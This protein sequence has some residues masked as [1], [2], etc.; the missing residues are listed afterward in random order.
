VRGVVAT[1]RGNLDLAATSLAEALDIA[2]LH[3]SKMRLMQVFEALGGLVVDSRPDLCV[4]L[5][6]AAEQLRGSLGAIPLPNEQKRASRLLG[7]AKR[8]LGAGA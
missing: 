2:T 4:R 3:S 1:E 8:R 7:T 6:S 5:V